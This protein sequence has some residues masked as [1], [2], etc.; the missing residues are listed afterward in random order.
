LPAVADAVHPLPMIAAGGITDGRRLAT[1][2]ALGADAGWFRTR[3]LASREV[4]ELIHPSRAIDRLSGMPFE[5][6][7]P[8]G[9]LCGPQ[10]RPQYLFT[11]ADVHPLAVNQ[12]VIR[13]RRRADEP[14]FEHVG[15]SRPIMSA[16]EIVH[17]L[18]R[19]AA[20]ILANLHATLSGPQL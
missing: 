5:P 13:V 2:L 19:D 16:A 10:G 15:K 20:H 18:S 7:W 1:V 8:E 12:S 11:I 6:N 3:F 14:E 9:D 17:T 4:C